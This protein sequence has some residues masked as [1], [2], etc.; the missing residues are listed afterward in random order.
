MISGVQSEEKGHSPLNQ[1]C[2]NVQK[3]D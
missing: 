3:Q 1:L 2:L